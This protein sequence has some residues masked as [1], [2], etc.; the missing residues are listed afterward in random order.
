MTVNGQFSKIKQKPMSELVCDFCSE[1]VVNKMS[2][3]Y[4]RFKRLEI[5][6][7]SECWIDLLDAME[8]PGYPPVW[9]KKYKDT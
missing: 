1:R 7:C 5:I 9:L 2:F 3:R 6:S 4:F 8:P